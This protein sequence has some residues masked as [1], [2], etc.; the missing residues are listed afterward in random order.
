LNERSWSGPGY[1]SA[2]TGSHP[3]VGKNFQQ[4]GMF[5]T[6]VDDM[7]GNNPPFPRLDAGFHLG[8]HSSG[9]DALMNQSADIAG[10]QF[11]DQ[12]AR[13]VLDAQ[14]IS[15]QNQFFRLQGDCQCP[16][17][18]IG[19]DIIGFTPFSHTDWGDDGYQGGL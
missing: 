7:G 15:Q 1:D 9:H 14:N 10:L 17:Y 18:G 11:T 6:T 8:D 5:D 4:Q 12:A 16:G 19:I 13:L 2:N 3:F